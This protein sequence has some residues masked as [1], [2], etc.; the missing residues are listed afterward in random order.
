MTRKHEQPDETEIVPARPH[1]LGAMM[2]TLGAVSGAG[3]GALAGGPPGAILGGIV[4]AIAGASS[5]WAG[6]EHTTAT[7][8]ADKTL[9]D[10][11]GVTSGTIGEPSLEHPPEGRSN[12]VSEREVDASPTP[13]NPRSASW[14]FERPPHPR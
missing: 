13:S 4:G 6:D 8:E 5:G 10:Q 2:G 14:P 7:L 1:P 11:I 3:L 12:P 9:D